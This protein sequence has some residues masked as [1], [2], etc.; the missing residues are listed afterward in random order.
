[1]RVTG[2][3]AEE[4]FSFDMLRLG[5]LPQTLVV[6]GPNGAGKTNLLRL[7][8]VAVTGLDRAAGFSDEAYRALVRF[9]EGPAMS[10]RL[11]QISRRR[12]WVLRSLS[13]GSAIC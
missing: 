5:D 11:R 6:V 4:L 1:M 13:R 10:A 8:Q 2:I 9:A 3:Q 7:L 12:V